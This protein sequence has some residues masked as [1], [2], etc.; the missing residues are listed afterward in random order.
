M[1]GTRSKPDKMVEDAES[2]METNQE[3]ILREIRVHKMELLLKIAKKAEVQATEIKTQCEQLREELNVNVM[4]QASTRIVALETLVQRAGIRMTR[5]LCRERW[6]NLNKMSLL[7]S[8][9]EDLEARS[10]RCNLHI[11]GVKES[12]FPTSYLSCLRPHY[13][14]IRPP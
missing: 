4:G 3:L 14:W 8:K 7:E 5:V 13:T 2:R 9:H 6:T 11:T 10:R 1:P 12:I